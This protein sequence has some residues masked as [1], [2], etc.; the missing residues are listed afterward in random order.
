[1]SSLEGWP[2]E[3]TRKRNVM[4]RWQE[5]PEEVMKKCSYY[6]LVYWRNLKNAHVVRHYFEDFIQKL[7]NALK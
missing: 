7:P 6:C 5:D 2:S 4:A 1:M 3:W